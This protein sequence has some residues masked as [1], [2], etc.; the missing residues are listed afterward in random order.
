[1][2][3]NT[4]FDYTK[5]WTNQS[6][7]PTYEGDETKVRADMQELFNQIRDALNA[8]A[9]AVTAA[10]VAFTPGSYISSENVQA[11]IEEVQTQVAQAQTGQ[12]AAGAV[13]TD[14]IYDGAVTEGKIGT[15]AVTEGKIGTG[16]VTTGKIADGAV[17]KDKLATALKNE[18][19][20]KADL[21]GG[22]VKPDQA[23]KAIV[24]VGGN[25]SLLSTD[26]GK[27]LYCT[28]ISSVLQ[29]TIP[30][31]AV[32]PLPVGTEID[33]VA[34]GNYGVNFLLGDDRMTLLNASNT[35]TLP[36]NGVAHLKKW[37]ENIWSVD[38]IPR[39]N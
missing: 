12:L 39:S 8:L 34:A 22:K 20:G 28:N 17:T 24:T 32:V 38:G 25:R 26:E 30:Y 2:P 35:E 4:E 3:I 10:N 13:T 7:F 18:I 1:M 11:A 33:V 15:G 14:K 19:E 27:A 21:V 5:K 9:Q 31:N 29:L 37:A 36:V 6:D 23:S 16:A